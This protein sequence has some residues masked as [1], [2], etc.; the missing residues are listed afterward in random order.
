[1]HSAPALW[2]VAPEHAELRAGSL[3][4]GVLIETLFSAISRGTERLVYAGRVPQS[5]YDRMRCP[6][7]EGSFPFPVKYG[8]S[9]VGRIAEGAGR[10]SVVFALAPHQTHFRASEATL[11]PVPGPVPP[12]RAVLGA[13]METALNLLWDSG[14]GAGDRIAIIGAGVVGCLTAY[15]ATRLP[16]A[17]VTLVDLQAS[18]ASLA[19]SLG[20][21]FARPDQVPTDCDVVLHL[22]ATSAGLTTALTAAGM[23]GTVVEGSWF[24]TGTTPVALGGAFHSRRLRLVSSQVGTVPPYQASR[25]TFA[26]RRAKALELLADPVLDVLFSGESPFEELPRHYGA[27]LAEPETLCHRIRYHES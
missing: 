22:T 25:W 17:E 23:E 13:N 24:G 9:A 27:I 3:G 1:M 15:L 11:T 19:K 20:C 18:R 7:Q 6:G 16:G 8:Y 26:R 14:A 5:E 4:D 21:L 12:E 2:C 10:G